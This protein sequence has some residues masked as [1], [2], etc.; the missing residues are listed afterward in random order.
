MEFGRV[1]PKEALGL[2]NIR[3]E[4]RHTLAKN[5]F[6]D[7]DIENCHPVLL[8]QVCK[9]NNIEC[10]YLEE[11]VN[12]R[13]KYLKEVMDTYNVDRDKAKKLFIIIMYFGGFNSWADE[14][15]IKGE[16]TKNLI[17]FKKEV[18][19]IGKVIYNN[20][21]EIKKNVKKRKTEQKKKDYNE[22]GSVV[23]YYL[24]ELECR[25][26]ENIYTYC[27]R[28][29][30]IKNKIAVLC[31]DGLMIQK[32]NYKSE[33]LNIFSDI[34]K[35]K[36]GFDLKFVV[37]DMNNDYL[38]I[39]DKHILS[40]NEISLRQMDGYNND[41]DLNSFEIFKIT[42]FDEFFKNDLNELGEE[43]YIKFFELTKSYKYFNNFHAFFYLSSKYYIIKGSRLESYADFN[44]SFNEFHF[45]HN[46]IKYKF[47][48]MFDMSKNKKVYSSLDFIPNNKYDD[49]I[50]NL[51][52]G[53]KY[54]S[55]NND[56]NDEIVKPYLDHIKFIC[57]NDSKQNEVYEYILNWMSHIVQKPEVKTDV[58]LVF[59]SIIEGAGKNI[60]FDI[61][62]KLMGSYSA[63]FKDTD[64]LTSRFNSQ[65]M[66]KLFC[67][68]DE[69]NARAQEVANELK[70]IITRKDEVIE[71][72]GKDKIFCK[73]Y[74]NYTFTTN[75]ENVFKVSNCDRRYLFIEC[76]DEKK[77]L[78]YFTPL[79]DLLNDDIKLKH[80]FNF[81]KTRDISNFNSRNIV[82]TEYKQ[83]L[84]LAN[85]PSYI[86][87]IKDELDNYTNEYLTTEQLYKKSIDYAKYNKLSST[88][89]QDLF[90]KQF[91]RVF[92]SFQKKKNNKSYY[93]FPEN[94]KLEVND[95]ISKNFLN[96][97]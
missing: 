2:H 90:N 71:F 5:T 96:N 7:I 67:V 85:A 78:E 63:R 31:A 50:Y 16:P 29:N 58:A 24:Q 56:F 65:M 4:I 32:E 52:Q 88:Y 27:T 11:Y 69:I 21:N 48:S 61:F 14:F 33:L 43:K 84:M 83:R 34:S 47:T 19:E 53:F 12:N 17:R 57:S 22:V 70:D 28:N 38:D 73:D 59:Y 72:K 91:K 8:Y 42:K 55:E 25:I 94:S 92:G 18:Q 39:L 64:D 6:V 45:F 30:I 1:N 41:I 77:S 86:R 46:R 93:Y 35:K 37:K 82:V 51:F 13:N 49:E 9:A 3:R 89:T 68:G 36:F 26:L 60:I 20:N 66:G 81:C 62:S 75:N 40:D 10:D 74:K 23:S 54:D 80:L 97:S 95:C 76:P 79:V 87:F 44:N 15:N